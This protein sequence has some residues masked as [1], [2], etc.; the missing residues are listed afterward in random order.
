MRPAAAGAVIDLIVAVHRVIAAL[1]R[2][3]LAATS[4]Y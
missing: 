3:E 2:I 1:R 4:F